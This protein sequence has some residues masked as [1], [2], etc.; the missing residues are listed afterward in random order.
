M[1]TME[2]WINKKFS[3][4]YVCDV[5]KTVATKLPVKKFE[6]EQWWTN[7]VSVPSE[8]TLFWHILTARDG[9]VP[10]QSIFSKKSLP[11]WQTSTWRKCRSFSV[12]VC[13]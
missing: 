1:V 4:W 10:Y 6:T 2:L 11:F 9:P 5:T 7:A 13:Y 3:L 8:T 12:W